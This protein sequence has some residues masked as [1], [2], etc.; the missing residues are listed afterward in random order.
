MYGVSAED[1]ELFC[2]MAAFVQEKRR[3]DNAGNTFEAVN[4]DPTWLPDPEKCHVHRLPFDIL[5]VIFNFVVDEYRDFACRLDTRT[6]THLS[7][8]RSLDHVRARAPLNIARVCKSWREVALETPS[9]WTQIGPSSAPFIRTF[10]A[11][12]KSEL[13]D[14]FWE[15][16][17]LPG[18]TDAS[19]RPEY[20]ISFFRPLRDHLHRLNTLDIWNAPL[21]VYYEYLTSPAPQLEAICASNSSVGNPAIEP[22]SVPKVLFGGHTP[23]LR[24]LYTSRVCISLDTRLL[25]NLIHLHI[26]G[27]IYTRSKPQQLIAVLN[28]CPALE[29]VKLAT[30]DFRSAFPDPTVQANLPLLEHFFLYEMPL[31]AVQYVLASTITSPTTCLSLNLGNATVGDTFPAN[32]DYATRFPNILRIRFLYIRC[33][34]DR[35]EHDNI[36]VMGYE[37]PMSEDDA[38]QLLTLEFTRMRPFAMDTVLSTLES[39]PMPALELVDLIG[40]A[41]AAFT[42]E[43]LSHFLSNFAAVTTLALSDEVTRFVHILIITAESR[44]VLC[45]SLQTLQIRR[46]DIRAKK[47]VK[48]VKSRQAFDCPLVE[49]ELMDCKSI[50]RGGVDKLEALGVTVKWTKL[51]EEEDATLDP[52]A[53]DPA[54]SGRFSPSFASTPDRGVVCI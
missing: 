20:A 29:R 35:F 46:S 36:E 17:K 5:V 26:E 34:Y 19:Q 13:L 51:E 38:T 1:L 48:L 31:D 22:L 40:F 47:L 8:A 18:P 14:I 11:R 21:S 6:R 24:S 45:P 4:D 43:K 50:N 16:T 2:R 27:V 32:V 39:L 7:R 30:I 25:S 10:L 37:N 3:E 9:L 23:R 33:R 28:A 53:T 44:L 52:D 41:H 54:F 15:S 12:S 42:A 49:L